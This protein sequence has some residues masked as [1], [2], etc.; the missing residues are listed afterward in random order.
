VNDY[1]LLEI[2]SQWLNMIKEPQ[3]LLNYVK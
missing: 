1:K 3:S 2:I